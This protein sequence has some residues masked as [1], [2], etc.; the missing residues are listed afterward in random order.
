L[1]SQGQVAILAET[2][3]SL[4]D[5]YALQTAI[6]LASG[7]PVVNGVAVPVIPIDKPQYKQYTLKH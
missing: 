3:H 1:Q 4:S 7:L 5:A 2:L 6:E